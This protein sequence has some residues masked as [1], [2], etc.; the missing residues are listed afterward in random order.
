M[1]P[2]IA[3]GRDMTPAATVDVAPTLAR[4]L[5]VAAPSD[6]DGHPLASVTRH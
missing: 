4:M 5:Q 1:G 6:L 2:H 3:S